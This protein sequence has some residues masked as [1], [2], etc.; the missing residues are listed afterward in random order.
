[1]PERKQFNRRCW[2]PARY[3]ADVAP[4]PEIMIRGNAK[5]APE[6]GAILSKLL[7]WVK[8]GSEKGWRSKLL[9]LRASEAKIGEIAIAHCSAGRGHQKAVDQGHEAAER[10]RRGREADG[11]S[12]G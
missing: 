6:A 9:H 8:W 3:V 1:M 7:I 11:G 10:G 4:S 12:L 2:G 5:M